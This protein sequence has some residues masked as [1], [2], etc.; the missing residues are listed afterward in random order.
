MPQGPGEP[1]T[2][3]KPRAGY[4]QLEKVDVSPEAP[5][6]SPPYPVLRDWEARNSLFSDFGEAPLQTSLEQYGMKL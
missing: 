2:S 3:R 6:A 4:R 1:Q 5:E